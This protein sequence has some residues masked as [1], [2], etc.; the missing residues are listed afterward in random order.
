MYYDVMFQQCI[1]QTVGLHYAVAEG[2]RKY[3]ICND[4]VNYIHK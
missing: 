3:M 2:E 1:H 4:E